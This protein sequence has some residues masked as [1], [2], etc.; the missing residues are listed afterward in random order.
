M[1]EGWMRW[2]FDTWKLPYAT[3]RNETLRAGDLGALFDVLVIPDVSSSTLDQGR[4]LGSAPSEFTRGLEPD[5]AIAVEEFVR[6]GG[7]LLTVGSS[8]QWAIDLF[9]FPLVD[10][11]R[12]KKGEGDAGFSCP[13][14]VLRG[15]PEPSMFTAGL[16]ESVALFF[17][18]AAAWRVESKKG[19]G[20]DTGPMETL[21]RYAPT[22]LL[23]SGW[24]RAP[25]T[26][27]D[28]A[29]WVRAR[30]GQGQVHLFG[31]SPHYRGW[32]QQTFAL[33]FRA[34]LLEG[35]Q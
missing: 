12:E 2:V 29:A 6:A 14:S 24:I 22:R 19:S 13:G 8:S 10:T 27:E 33:L 26:I 17:S 21:L 5:G 28:H 30:H 4:A 32:S 9:E 3:V 15:I 20:R 23:I 11:T 31:F 16:P 34:I 7:T 35:A 18:G 1:D 25:A